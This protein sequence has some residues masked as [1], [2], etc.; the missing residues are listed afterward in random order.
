MAAVFAVASV[1]TVAKAQTGDA[2]TVVKATSIGV[3][4]SLKDVDTLIVSVNANQVYSKVMYSITGY[5]AKASGTVA[6]KSY[7]E[8]SVNGNDW[9]KLDSITFTNGDNHK[10]FVIPQPHPG[11]TQRIHHQYRIRSITVGTCEIDPITFKEL[12]AKPNPN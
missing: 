11:S 6:G 5:F 2:V 4:D 1:I 9:D 3:K 10:T 7:L 8:G 12:W